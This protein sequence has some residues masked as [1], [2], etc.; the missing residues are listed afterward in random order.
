MYDLYDNH[1]RLPSHLNR[2]RMDPN[3]EIKEGAQGN[4]IAKGAHDKFH[5]DI[6]KAYDSIKDFTCGLHLDFHGYAK[7][8]HHF[9]QIGYLYTKDDLNDR[10]YDTTPSIKALLDRNKDKTEI[11][12]GSKSLGR[13]FN[14]HNEDACPSP[15]FVV[16]GF[17]LQQHSN[18]IYKPAGPAVVTRSKI[19]VLLFISLFC[20]QPVTTKAWSIIS[21]SR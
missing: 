3:R 5:S 7:D 20:G 16:P 11:I 8:D 2:S 13:L 10:T 15:R 19:T 9:T 17:L 12:H 21:Y 1:L 4:D 6:R 18:S 14:D